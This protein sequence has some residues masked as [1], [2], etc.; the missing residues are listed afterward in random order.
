MTTSKR[1]FNLH[2]I[3]F[4]SKQKNKLLW[5]SVTNGLSEGLALHKKKTLNWLYQYGSTELQ[6]NY[7]ATTLILVTNVFQASVL[8]L[9]NDSSELTV[10]EII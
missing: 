10:E 4:L 6:T 8:C 5:C 1:L 2:E 3:T 7:T 9:F